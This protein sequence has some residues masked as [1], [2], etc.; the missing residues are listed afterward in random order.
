MIGRPSAE[1][2]PHIAARNRT[3]TVAPSETTAQ[4][5]LCSAASKIPGGTS[6]Q[7][8]VAVPI[9]MAPGAPRSSPAPAANA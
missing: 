9:A 2:G 4:S 8:M 1:S 7:A 5:R 6:D 3:V